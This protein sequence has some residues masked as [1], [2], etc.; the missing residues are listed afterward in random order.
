MV[1]GGRTPLYSAQ[2]LQEFGYELVIFPTASTYIT[3]QA[4]FS[5]MTELKNAGTTGHIVD[6]M[7]PFTQF[8]EFVGLPAVRELE[9]KYLPQQKKDG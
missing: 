6:R 9:N 7:I 1:E 5:A 3:A 2:E 4:I 8:N